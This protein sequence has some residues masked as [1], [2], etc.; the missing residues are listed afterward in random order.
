MTLTVG[1]TGGIASGKSLVQQGFEALG[2]PVLDADLVAREVVAR[3]SA[4]L[5][6]IAQRFG[7]D[8]LLP[9]GELDRRRMRE[10]VFADRDARTQ[11]EAITHPLIRARMQAWQ[12]SQTAPYCILSV[13]LLV[14]G[15]MAQLVHRVL[16]VDVP[17]DIQIE[18]LMRRDAID[19]RLA[20]QMLAAQVSRAARL[21]RA[22]DIFL[23]TGTV[24]DVDAA[25]AE[26][27][28]FYLDIVARNDLHAAGRRLPHPEKSVTI[29]V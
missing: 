14:E 7:S 11:L 27:H 12:A 19:R 20:E 16:V 28:H 4:G 6:A 18:R 26:L 13:A 5:A 15:F 24:A 23:N 8:F 1:L 22:D 29:T 17:E 9:S 2:V 3:G 10:H 25:V 21:A